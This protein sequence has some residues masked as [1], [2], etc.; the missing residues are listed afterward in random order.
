[1]MLIIIDI[2]TKENWNLYRELEP[3]PYPSPPL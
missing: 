1:M 3:P 2:E